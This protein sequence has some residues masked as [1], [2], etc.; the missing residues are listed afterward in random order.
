MKWVRERSLYS[1][2]LCVDIAMDVV[3][4]LTKDIG[5]VVEDDYTNIQRLLEKM[6]NYSESLTALGM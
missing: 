5:I 1:L 2:Q 4:M 6:Q 3:A